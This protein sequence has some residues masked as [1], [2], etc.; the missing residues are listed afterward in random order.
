MTDFLKPV[1]VEEL[2][3]NSASDIDTIRT[4][5]GFSVAIFDA[6][7]LPVLRH[8]AHSVQNLPLATEFYHKPGGAWDFGLFVSTLTLRVA[9]TRM[10]FP[11]LDSIERRTLE[12]ESLF[13]A[14]A[15]GLA[16]GIALLAQNTRVSDADGD[17]Y[18]MLTAQVPLSEWLAKANAPVFN[19]RTEEDPLTRAECAAIAARFLPIKIISPFDLRIVRSI[20][21]A[22]YPQ[23]SPNAL[24]TTLS[25]VVRQAT[26]AAIEKYRQNHAAMFNPDLKAAPRLTGAQAQRLAQDMIDE[27]NTATA[28]NVLDEEAGAAQTPSPAAEVASQS[29]AATPAA[30]AANATTKPA[31]GGGTGGVPMPRARP[32]AQAAPP[33]PDPETG[34][35]MRTAEE[36]LS[37]APQELKDWFKALRHHERYAA[38]QSSIRI[39][40]NGIELPMAPLGSLGIDLP[41]VV[42]LMRTAGMYRSTSKD[43]Q[44]VVLYE[45]LKPLF[46]EE[47]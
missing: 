13:A 37:A 21:G 6:A 2:L 17:E 38:F 44:R 12:K 10:F 25:R 36:Y 39:T 5:A 18:H 11:T 1:P 29:G 24:E 28:T 31:S 34:E 20:Y 16:T 3:A 43:A 47:A 9:E 19:W 45:T 27:G 4:A 8:Y 15:A 41:T 32:P 46:F 35:V 42:G 26:D 30:Q 40:E 23:S 33:A 22:I 7:F 14:F